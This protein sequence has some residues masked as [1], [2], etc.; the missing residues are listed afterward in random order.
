VLPAE[1]LHPNSYCHAFSPVCH[2]SVVR[3]QLPV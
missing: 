3:G 2:W 1:L